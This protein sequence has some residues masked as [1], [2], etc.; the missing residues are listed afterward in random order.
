MSEAIISRRGFNSSGKNN[1]E[2]Q[3]RTQYFYQSTYW[4][5]PM[6]EGNISVIMIGGG[7]GG[8]S[9][10][11][12]SYGAGGGSGN[13]ANGEFEVNEAESIYILLSALEDLMEVMLLEELEDHHLLVPIYLRLVGEVQP[14][15][16]MVY[17]ENVLVELEVLEVVV[18][19]MEV[20]D[21]SLEQVHVELMIVVV[22]ELKGVYM[23]EGVEQA[24]LILVEMVGHMEEVEEV[25]GMTKM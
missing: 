16:H 17:T 22:M 5:V 11:R 9:N 10:S 13:L 8:A 20:E 19:L 7:G 6:H 15:L 14:F 18:L 2:R 4:T 24:G 21:I 25:V 3:F 23:V 1:Y 12:G